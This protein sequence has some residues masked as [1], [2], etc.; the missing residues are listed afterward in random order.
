MFFLIMIEEMRNKEPQSFWASSKKMPCF[1]SWIYAALTKV[2]FAIK[3]KV[4]D[5]RLFEDKI[6]LH[7]FSEDSIKEANCHPEEANQ[8]CVGLFLKSLLSE[9]YGCS[10]HCLSSK[11]KRT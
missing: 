10:H 11:T 2:L 5:E 6:I 3:S 8:P 4:K 9:L 7:Q 1:S